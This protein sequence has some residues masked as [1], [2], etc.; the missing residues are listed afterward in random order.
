[1]GT[2]LI[3]IHGVPLRLVDI[4]NAL[5]EPNTTDDCREVNL[6]RPAGGGVASFSLFISHNQ[7]YWSFPTGHVIRKNCEFRNIAHRA[8]P[9]RCQLSI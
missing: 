8:K 7:S 3:S 1:M 9:C 2:I 6:Q 5:I 4:A